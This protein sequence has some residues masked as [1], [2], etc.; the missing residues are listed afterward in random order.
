[1]S[2][3]LRGAASC[4]LMAAAL[5]A[6]PQAAEAQ[7]YNRLVVFGDSLSDNGNLFAFTGGTQPPAP[8]YVNGR[9]SNGPVFT[10]LLGFDATGFGTTSGS[11]NYA[12][13]GARTDFA[14]SPP[15]MRLQLAAYLQNGGTFGD[16]DLVSVLGGA[17]NLF[18]GI[19]GAATSPTPIAALN[20]VASAAAADVNALVS[21][22]AQAGAGTIMVVNLPRLSLTPQFLNSPAGP[23]AD[24]GVGTFNTALLT[25]LRTTAA[26][27]DSNI[28]YVDLFRAGDFI[29]P[30]AQRFGITNI[31]DT[32]LNETTGSICANPDGYFYWD[33]VHPTAAGHR[34]IASLA[35]DYIYYGDWGA[36]ATVLG[37]M[38]YGRRQDALDDAGAL[39][40]DAAG[41]G[42]GTRLTMM[43]LYENTTY[44]ARGVV[45]ETDTQAGGARLA[46]EHS[47]NDTWRFG[48]AGSILSGDADAG[49]MSFDSESLS[50]DA[51][52]GWRSGMV[53]VNA[54]GGVSAENYDD[55][56]R[57]TQLA[58]AIH[59]AGTD[60]FSVGAKIEGG[61][62]VPLGGL[63][64]VPRVGLNWISAEVDGYRETGPAAQLEFQD[65]TVEA[66]SGEAVLALAGGDENLGFYASGGYRHA[67]DDSADPVRVG[68]LGNTAQ[69]LERDFDLPQGE[70][71]LAEAGISARI[72]DTMRVS[73]GYRGRF[74]DAADS[75]LAGVAFTL[76]LP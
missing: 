28:I 22:V 16:G 36:Q 55:I 57:M 4:A 46:L 34:I 74:G 27:T 1:M 35:R 61:V 51:W 8:F 20:L 9:F 49:A 50:F 48:L 47:P 31:T 12:F 38:A 24:Q 17:N 44:D 29:A 10:E 40:A 37:E 45:A 13:G 21:Q 62:A 76:T 30:N 26:G 39:M 73:A 23:L 69:I 42:A 33:G 43:G 66:L 59:T 11:V 19:P 14:M 67:F 72:S 41:W 65:R 75:H 54:Y 32:C 25:G 3:L 58:P 6:A 68:I 64:L 63:A 70:E 56:E 2:R 53:F 15:G 52:G 18:Q 60:A 5:M 7:T 71:W